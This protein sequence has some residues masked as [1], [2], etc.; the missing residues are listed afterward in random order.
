MKISSRGLLS[1][2][3]PG[4]NILLT[5]SAAFLVVYLFSDL[6][7]SYYPKMQGFEHREVRSVALLRGLPEYKPDLF[8]GKQLFNTSTKRAIPQGKENLILLGISIGGKKLAMIKDV[9]ENKDHY[10]T[11]GDKVGAFKVKRIFTDKVILE[12]DE[13]TLVLS[14]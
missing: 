7:K 10:C 12:S 1:M 13:E 3:F 11:E 2:F 8:K 9:S 5:L 6:K 4:V 14:Q